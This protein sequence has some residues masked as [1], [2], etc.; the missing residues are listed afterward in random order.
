MWG[1]SDLANLH[2]I[3]SDGKPKI[4]RDTMHVKGHTFN[5]FHVEPLFS[6][7]GL[8]EGQCKVTKDC[9]KL[10]VRNGEILTNMDAVRRKFDRCYAGITG[11]G[12]DRFQLK[13]KYKQVLA[14]LQP[15]SLQKPLTSW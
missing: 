4:V 13:K 3:C 11:S 6:P 15:S 12:I 14:Q 9:L 5:H 7:A 1:F 8:T 2:V 10:V